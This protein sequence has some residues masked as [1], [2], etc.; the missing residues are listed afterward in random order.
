MSRGKEYTGLFLSYPLIFISSGP[1]I[2]AFLEMSPLSNMLRREIETSYL[3]GGH[4]IR[5]FLHSFSAMPITPPLVH[6]HFS[7]SVCRL[8][9]QKQ[10]AG[11]LLNYTLSL[12]EEAIYPCIFIMVN[13]LFQIYLD[14]ST[15]MKL[16]L[17]GVC[18]RDVFH[19]QTEIGCAVHLQ[20]M[21]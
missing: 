4:E 19:R 17:L 7:C 1:I 8:Q 11:V 14:T 13:S 18:F 9:V 3:E 15:C 16:Y 5:H 10:A 21:S 2:R 20:Y 6:L 12:T